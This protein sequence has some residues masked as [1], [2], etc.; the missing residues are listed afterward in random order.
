MVATEEVAEVVE[1]LVGSEEGHVDLEH[2]QGPLS[3]KVRGCC[4]EQIKQPDR[5]NFYEARRF[6]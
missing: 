3:P 2:H 5:A 6:T 4:C 1:D